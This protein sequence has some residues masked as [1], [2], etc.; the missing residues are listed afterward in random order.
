MEKEKKIFLESILKTKNLR[1]ALI[2][3]LYANRRGVSTNDLINFFKTSPSSFSNITKKLRDNEIIYFVNKGKE[4]Y[5]FLHED[6]LQYLQKNHPELENISIEKFKEM[7]MSLEKEFN[8]DINPDLRKCYI[9]A[10]ELLKMPKFMNLLINYSLKEALLF[11]LIIIL[12]LENKHYEIKEIANLLNITEIDAIDNYSK[13]L[14][15]LKTTLNQVI[16]DVLIE[17]NI[18]LKK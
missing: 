6:V 2:L 8:S 17:N 10:I 1:K 11:S 18:M 9:K 12:Y 4:H 13:V 15:L 5:Y 14:K 7:P 16:E 3:I